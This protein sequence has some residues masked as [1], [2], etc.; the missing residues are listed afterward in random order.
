MDTTHIFCM[1][2]KVKSGKTVYYR[3][4]MNDTNFITKFNI[5]PISCKT[6]QTSTKGLSDILTVELYTEEEFSMMK[7]ENLIESRTYYVI[8]DGFV[9]FF[10]ETSQLQTKNNI[11][12]IASPYQYESYKIWCAQENIKHPNRYKIHLIFIE[13]DAYTRAKR[14]ASFIHSDDDLAEFGRRILQDRNEFNVATKTIPELIDPLLSNVCIVQHKS[15]AK[16]YI[17][18]NLTKIK[19]YIRDNLK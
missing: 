10:T 9:H 3:G 5:S 2:G 1:V 16:D 14:A 15:D 8:P 18:K 6:T 12:C 13:A 19:R 7:S 17:S 11:L 4:I